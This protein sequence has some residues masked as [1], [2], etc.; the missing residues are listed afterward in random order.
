MNINNTKLKT[1]LLGLAITAIVGASLIAVGQPP[2]ARGHGGP[3][4]GPGFGGHFAHVLNLTDTQ[5]TQIKALREQAHAAAK[6][7]HEQIKP[8]REQM[9]KLIEAPAFNE[10]AARALDQQMM[11]AQIEIQVIYAKTEAAIF[12]LLTPEQK[13]KMTEMRQTMKDRHAK[14]A[15][16]DTDEGRRGGFGRLGN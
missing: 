9:Q 1:V 3:G 2:W 7:Y 16:D 6:P 5:K 12:Q 11:Q 8:I 15:L 14:E 13:A 10:T 4:G